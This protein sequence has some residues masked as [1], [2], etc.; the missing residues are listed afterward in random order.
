MEIIL[1]DIVAF[2]GKRCNLEMCGTCAGMGERRNA[3]EFW[4]EENEGKNH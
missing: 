2:R 3:N 1:K 4:S